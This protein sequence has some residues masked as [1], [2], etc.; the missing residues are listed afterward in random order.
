MESKQYTC[1]HCAN[2]FIPSKRSA[3]RM[4]LRKDV[5]CNRECYNAHASKKKVTIICA[6]GCGQSRVVSPSLAAKGARFFDRK[7]ADKNRVKKITITCKCGCGRSREMNPSDVAD[8]RGVFFNL[9]CMRE[10]Q[11]TQALAKQ[12]TLA[13]KES[14]GRIIRRNTNDVINRLNA[15]KTLI[16]GANAIAELIG[17][18]P[19]QVG[20]LARHEKY[21]F[22]KPRESIS[23]GNAFKNYYRIADV[24]AYKP[25]YEELMKEGAVKKYQPPNRYQSTESLSSLAVKFFGGN[26]KIL[27]NFGRATF[28]ADEK[29]PEIPEPIDTILGKAWNEKNKALIVDNYFSGVWL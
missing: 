8:K 25:V 11:A 6:C 26:P 15:D 27:E 14:N 23:A 29:N 22:P 17:C 13:V 4:A 19:E 18:A 7:C 9:E 5:F 1:S 24:E 10:Y 16:S 28:I 2:K 21:K 12:K 3:P 20:A